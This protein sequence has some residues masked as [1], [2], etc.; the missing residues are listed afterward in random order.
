VVNTETKQVLKA[1][2]GKLA[3]EGVS[4]TSGYT[5]LTFALEGL[6]EDDKMFYTLFEDKFTD[7]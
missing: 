3:L 2:A 7:A 6:P 5:K 4:R 1:P